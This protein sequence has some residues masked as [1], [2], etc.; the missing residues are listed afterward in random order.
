MMSTSELEN[1]AWRPVVGYEGYYEVSDQ[2]RVRSLDQHGV[3]SRGRPKFRKGVTLKPSYAGTGYPHVVLK[4]KSRNVHTLVMESFVGPRPE[5]MQVRHL[6]SN[7]ANARA[8][9][10]AY[11]TPAEN[12][13][14]RWLAGTHEALMENCRKGHPFTEE[15][16]IIVR[17]NGVY[18]QRSCRACNQERQARYRE[19]KRKERDA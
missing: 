3:D 13:A 4:G 1:E 10:L 7:R 14:D 12:Q 18:R 15:N 17:R 9:N 2:G 11:G 19:R 5:G 6:D 16:T 8:D